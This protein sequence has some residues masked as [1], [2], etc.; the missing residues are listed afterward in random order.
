VFIANSTKS[1]DAL[2]TEVS[3]DGI[4]LVLGTYVEPKTPLLIEVGDKEG[5]PYLD[6][7]AHVA[8]AVPLANGNWCCA[9]EWA[10]KLTPDEMFAFRYRTCHSPHAIQETIQQALPKWPR[11]HVRLPNAVDVGRLSRRILSRCL[12]SVQ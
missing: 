8:R 6:L 5:L 10:R 2:V 12:G 11:L 4:G 9:C 7:V 1:V 3:E